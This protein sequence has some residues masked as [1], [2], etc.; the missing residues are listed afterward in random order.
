MS[1]GTKTEYLKS[2]RDEYQKA[3]RRD[4]SVILRH[5]MLVTGLSRKRIIRLLNSDPKALV[6]R[7][8]GRRD[9]HSRHLRKSIRRSK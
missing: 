7:K 4:K 9:G 5:S 2:I 6:S 8:L 3:N 1:N